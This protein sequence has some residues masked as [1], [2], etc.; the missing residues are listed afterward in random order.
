MTSGESNAV[1][2]FGAGGHAKV[3]VATRERAG[4]RVQTLY[5]DDPAKIGG[6]VLGV[7]VLGANYAENPGIAAVIAGR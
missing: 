4:W 2:V 7:P 5:D 1:V 3:V 6:R